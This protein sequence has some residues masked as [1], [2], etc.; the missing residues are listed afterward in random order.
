MRFIPRT[1]AELGGTVAVGAGI[2]LLA[3]IVM[4]VVAGV[5]KP[6]TKAAIKG[7]L[8]AYDKVRVT[9]AETVEAI[10]DIAAE[11]K[12][13]LK[14]KEAPKPKAAKGKGKGKKAA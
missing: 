5:L 14:V 7:G 12:A 9:T 13:E 2:V 1:A 8:I 3:P 4:P 10:E 11:A 6:L